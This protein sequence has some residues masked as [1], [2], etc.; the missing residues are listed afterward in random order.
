[1]RKSKH[2][3]VKILDPEDVTDL[4]EAQR[5][6]YV[7]L[8]YQPCL[9]S[10]GRIKWLT[11]SQQVST[12]VRTQSKYRFIPKKKPRISSY[13][14]RKRGYS[15]PFKTFIRENWFFLV[16]IAMII[17]GLLILIRYWNLIM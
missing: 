10:S 4:T 12:I 1:M 9:L 14:R 7:S 17:I 13:K 11:P 16:L 5:E 2:D 6:H 3:I 8:G 15:S